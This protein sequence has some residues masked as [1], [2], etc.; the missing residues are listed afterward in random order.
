MT[1]RARQ[2][3]ATRARILLIARERFAE[4]GYD[5]TTL[6]SVAKAAGVAVGT[7]CLHFPTKADLVAAALVDLVDDR[8]AEGERG[9]STDPIDGL[10]DRIRPLWLHYAQDPALTRAFLRETLFLTGEWE[11]R[12]REQILLFFARTTAHLD[13]ARSRGALAREL[14]PALASQGFFA[15]YFFVL[16]QLVRLPES[17]PADERVAACLL[18]LR[19]LTE[20]RLHGYLPLEQP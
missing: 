11:Q 9:A 5:D 3:A 17:V 6:S 1:R 16:L 4:A 10:L 12:F 7:V 8:L 14:D 20:Q 15:D 19:A 2:R 18:Q 13:A